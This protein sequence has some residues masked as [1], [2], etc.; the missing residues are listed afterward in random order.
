MAIEIPEEVRDIINNPESIKVLTTISRDGVPHA[1]FKGS[2]KAREGNVLE[3]LEF[4]ESSQ[5][6][7]NMVYS[8]WFNKTVAIAVLF[9][10]K[11]FQ[12]KGKVQRAIIAGAEFES[13]YK[14]IQKERNIDL[15]TVYLIDVEEIREESFEK[16]RTE[17]LE[18]HPI[19]QHLDLLI[20]N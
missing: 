2:L 1:V 18:Q 17:E 4:I 7:K 5:T 9:G 20:K 10:D 12:L 16:R 13:R 6:N 3:Y 15:S 8:I 14:E 11:S 19:L